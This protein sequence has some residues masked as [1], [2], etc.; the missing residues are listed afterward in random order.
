[1]RSWTPACSLGVL[2]KGGGG[3]PAGPALS[4]VEKELTACKLSG[5]ACTWTYAA[6][7][8]I[9]LLTERGWRL[10]VLRATKDCG[11]WCPYCL[12]VSALV[13]VTQPALSCWLVHVFPV[14]CCCFLLVQYWLYS[15]SVPGLIVCQSCCSLHL[16]AVQ[17]YCWVTLTDT[18]CSCA[19][20]VVW[21]WGH[22]YILVH[23]YV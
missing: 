7:G 17:H 18:L 13:C 9:S 22:N 8:V 6:P 11:H 3:P 19:K 10:L 4:S 14:S 16:C 1:M 5:Q 21:S 20:L 12:L 23:D 2:W 15:S